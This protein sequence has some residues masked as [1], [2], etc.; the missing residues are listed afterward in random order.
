MADL[1]LSICV[2]N[3]EKYI[4]DT[5]ESVLAQTYQDFNL[6]IVDDCSTDDSI[7]VIENFFLDHTR[8]HEV[9]R[10]DINKGIGYARHFAERKANTRFMMFMDADDM[11]YPKAIE[12]MYSRISCDTDLMTVGCYQEYIDIKGHKIGGGL[13]LGAK[14][15]EEFQE[16]ASKNKRIFMQVTAVYDR[17]LALSVGGFTIDGFQCGDGVRYQDYCEDLDLWTRMSDLYTKGKAIIVIPEVLCK[18]RKS[19]GMS[20]NTL[21]MILKMDYIKYNLLRRR[22]RQQELSFTE[23]YSN[24]THRQFSRMKRDA[25]SAENLRNGAM[26]LR[27]G[28]VFH[29]IVH[30]CKSLYYKPDYIVEKIS[31]NILH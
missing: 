11:L 18:Y 5:L 14:T 22:N 26:L 4:Y 10:F 21:P 6:L 1:T 12:K 8:Q 17:N 25:L 23:Y 9:V 15:K 31:K 13:Y 20:S 29:G 30:I 28:K 3:A 2:Y 7:K 27:K 16:A 19:S 24:L